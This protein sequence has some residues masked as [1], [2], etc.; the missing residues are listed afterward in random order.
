MQHPVTGGNLVTKPPSRFDPLTG[1]WFLNAF[2][3]HAE[4]RAPH[5]RLTR[6]RRS[7]L[8]LPRRRPAR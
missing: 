7:D 6:L 8:S 1:R 3:E 2:V 5:Y 4:I